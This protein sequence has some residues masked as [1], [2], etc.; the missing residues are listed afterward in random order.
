M[1]SL[2]ELSE[3]EHRRLWTEEATRRD[4]TPAPVEGELHDSPWIRSARASR[5]GRWSN[6][7]AGM[8]ASASTIRR[9]CRSVKVTP[10]RRAG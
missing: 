2:N 3:E 9:P 4:A 1:E 6:T 10:S 8:V 5:S 7:S